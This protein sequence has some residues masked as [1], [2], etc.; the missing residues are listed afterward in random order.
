MRP[1]APTRPRRRESRRRRTSPP[2]RTAH[3]RGRLTRTTP[4]SARTSRPTGADPRCRRVPP[5]ARRRRAPTWN[6]IVVIVASRHE[7]SSRH[8][9]DRDPRCVSLHAPTSVN[10][11]ERSFGA[12]VFVSAWAR[13]GGTGVDAHPSRP[14]TPAGCRSR[15]LGAGRARW[16]PVPPSECRSRPLGLTRGADASLDA[17]TSVNFVEGSFGAGVFVSARARSGGA[18]V[19]ARPFR[20]ITP[21]VRRSR[22]ADGGGQAIPWG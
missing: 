15:P 3:R 1:P 2:G 18:G 8:G 16:V 6:G 19:D 5:R 4:A 9:R 12:G 7:R 21:A 17:P 11:V 20:P 10:L 14:I 22:P 13:S